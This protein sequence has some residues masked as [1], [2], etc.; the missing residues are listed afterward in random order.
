M[1][2]RLWLNSLQ[3]EKQ[4]FGDKGKIL[5]VFVI[6]QRIILDLYIGSASLA[7]TSDIVSFVCS[8]TMY[9]CELTCS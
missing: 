1:E 7:K 6:N 4:I 5:A 8:Y 2:T 9:T 3:E